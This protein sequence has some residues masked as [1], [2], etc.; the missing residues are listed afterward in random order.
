M[1]HP[2]APLQLQTEDLSELEATS[3]SSECDS[4]STSRQTTPFDLSA[5]PLLR[6]KI[7]RLGAEER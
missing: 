4:C 2:A 1:I 5:G 7:Y 3:A 6:V